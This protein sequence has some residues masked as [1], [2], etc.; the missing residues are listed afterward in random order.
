M[1]IS[2]KIIVP[3]NTEIETNHCTLRVRHLLSFLKGNCFQLWETILS[4]PLFIVLKT[5]ILITGTPLES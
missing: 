5:S 2:V 4:P 1:S 3:K